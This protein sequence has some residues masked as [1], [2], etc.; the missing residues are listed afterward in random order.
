VSGR[1]IAALALAA[2][3]TAQAQA[4]APQRIVTLAPHLAELVCDV[5][6]CSRLVGVSAYTDQPAQAA[7]QPQ[8]GD[9]YAV[10]LEALLALHPDLVLAW[11]QAT[12]PA[13]IERLRRL[14]LRVEVPS[15][16][17]LDGIAGELR[18]LGRQLG[19][20]ATAN[21]AADTYTAQL[22][23]LRRRYAHVSR[24]RVFYQLGTDPA[25][26][27]NHR[28]TVSAA[29]ALCGGDNVFGD[30]PHIAEPVSAEAV[31]AARPQAVFYDRQENRAAMRTY[32]SRLPQVPAVR[33][34]ALYAIDGDLLAHPS[35]RVLQGIREVCQRL[36]ALRG[37]LADGR[38]LSR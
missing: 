32:W 25:Y 37:R 22:T 3:V 34:H 31:L 27:V 6:A 13:T 24:V 21:A 36:D 11:D 9:A 5:G 15:I 1:W 20:A 17:S 33:H 38:S 8:V 19:T 35:P 16:N 29:L 2:C 28:S 10:N 12:P 26:T 30:L 23:A 7:A 18:R 4:Q 14:G